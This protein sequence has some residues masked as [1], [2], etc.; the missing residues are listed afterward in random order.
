[1]SQGD[2]PSHQK[3]KSKFK[4]TRC[5][6]RINKEK[7]DMPWKRNENDSTCKSKSKRGSSI[8]YRKTFDKN[9]HQIKLTPETQIEKIAHHI[10]GFQ[11][12]NLSKNID[13]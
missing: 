13:E 5:Y 8:M 4:V 2:A 1:M 3:T 12:A 10:T 11:I 6:N 7:V 9:H